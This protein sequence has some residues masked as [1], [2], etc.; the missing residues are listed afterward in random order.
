MFVFIISA[1]GLNSGALF[2]TV[3]FSNIFLI[4]YF[5]DFVEAVNTLGKESCGF[6]ASATIE[7]TSDM[8]LAQ[9]SFENVEKYG[10]VAVIF[11]LEKANN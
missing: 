9:G 7:K 6:K 2:S 4:L 1:S 10:I 8:S 11:E 3:S 5:N